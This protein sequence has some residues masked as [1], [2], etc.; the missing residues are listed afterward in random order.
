MLLRLWLAVRAIQTGVEKFAG[1]KMTAGEIVKVDGVP[2][3]EGLS[4]VSS[5]KFYALDQYHGIPAGLL[6][7][8]DSEPLVLK[9]MLPLYDKVLGPAF[10]LLGIA[11]LLGLFYRTS[12]FV[13]GL[14]YISLTWGLILLKQDDGVSWLGVHMIIV[15]MALA[16]ASHNRFAVMKKW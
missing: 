10:L 12:L 9:A 8:F 7:K 5:A 4:A 3:S 16:L 1:T 11:I 2:N 6:K 15:V 14:I 13:L